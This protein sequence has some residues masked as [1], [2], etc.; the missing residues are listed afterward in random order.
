MSHLDAAQSKVGA[1]PKRK[2]KAP[3]DIEALDEEAESSEGSDWE[4]DWNSD[5][6]K[7]DEDVLVS[8]RSTVNMQC[9]LVNLFKG[10]RKEKTES[11]RFFDFH[12]QSTGN[13]A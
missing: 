4:P 6:D 13:A 1:A 7:E 8:H 3:S 12:L 9:C 5:K 11:S 10:E 2:R